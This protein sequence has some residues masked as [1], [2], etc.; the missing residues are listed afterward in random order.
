MAI[1][2]YS[3]SQGP[4]GTSIY[5]FVDVDVP[6]MYMPKLINKAVQNKSKTN[7][8]SSV[9]T[10]YPLVSVVDGLSVVRNTFR[11]KTTFT[12][13]QGVTALT[14]RERVFNEHVAFL[15][16]HKAK[17]IAGDATA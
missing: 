15:T 7:I 5:T 1:T 17:I 11:M 13:L 9:D 2:L 3:G 12:S 10:T 8:E 14:E 6:A 4:L 16:A